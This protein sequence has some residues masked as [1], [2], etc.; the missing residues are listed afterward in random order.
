MPSC[1]SPPFYILETEQ[2]ERQPCGSSVFGISSKQTGGKSFLQY[3]SSPPECPKIRQVERPPCEFLP[4][5][6]PKIRQ[7]KRPFCKY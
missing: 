5:E 6:Y 2:G 3:I 1:E 7:I 4:L